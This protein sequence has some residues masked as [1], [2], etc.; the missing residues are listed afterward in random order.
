MATATLEKRGPNQW[1][2]KIRRRGYPLETRT[3]ETKATAE[4]Y[5][6]RIERE[7]DEGV[8]V[9]HREAE[10]TTLGELLERYLEEV[11][12]KKKGADLE[13]YRI[14]ALLRHPLAA[15]FLASIRVADIASYR[16]ERLKVVAS[17]TV[18]RDLVILGHL[19]ETA[20]KDWGLPIENPVRMVRSPAHAKSRDRRFFA[21]EEKRLLTECRASRNPF[22]E[23]V[24]RLALETAMRRSE[25]VRLRWE[26]IDLER[27]TAHLPDTKNDEARTIPLSTVAIESL[28]PLRD[29]N[30]GDLG[31]YL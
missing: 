27:R 21:G 30:R 23:P 24:V 5:V 3:F 19:F 2:V 16:D 13:I 11:T 12:P 22:L 15:R 6:R 20:R 18:K 1:R 10:S 25:L 31:I 17:A 4:R 14:R 26:H 9:S 8:F 29:G 7:M 28:R